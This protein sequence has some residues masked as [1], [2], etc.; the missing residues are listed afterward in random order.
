MLN[1]ISWYDWITPSN[2]FAAIVVGLAVVVF[3]ALSYYFESRKL[4]GPLIVFLVGVAVI[5]GG[6]FLLNLIGFYD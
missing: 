5:F 6:V 4:K 3:A 2:P 1:S